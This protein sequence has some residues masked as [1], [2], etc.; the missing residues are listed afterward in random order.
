MPQIHKGGSQASTFQ[1]SGWK[2]K[3]KRTTEDVIDDTTENAVVEAI[4]VGPDNSAY[5]NTSQGDF[6]LVHVV[7]DTVFYYVWTPNSR[8]EC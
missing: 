2:R 8:Q 6:Q 1:V 5:A 4:A 7:I 3:R